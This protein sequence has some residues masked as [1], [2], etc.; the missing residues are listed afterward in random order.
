MAGIG[1]QLRKIMSSKTFGSVLQAYAYAAIVSS[2]PLILS[3]ASLALLGFF[4]AP[5]SSRE[6]VIVF[7]TAVTH[8]PA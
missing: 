8:I 7:F 2:G 5:Q 3:I 1:F 4:I 6:E